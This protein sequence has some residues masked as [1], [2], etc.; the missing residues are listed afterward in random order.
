[1]TFYKLE[2]YLQYFRFNNI[3]QKTPIRVQWFIYDEKQENRTRPF[4]YEELTAFQ[5]YILQYPNNFPGDKN[6]YTAQITEAPDCHE[7]DDKVSADYHFPKNV[8]LMHDPVLLP[9]GIRC[10]MPIVLSDL[11]NQDIHIT[12]LPFN[13]IAK[14]WV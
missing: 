1:M 9:N 13:V 6:Y 5:N 8:I 3:V 7:A 12:D 11:K 4:T 2:T 10:C 14:I